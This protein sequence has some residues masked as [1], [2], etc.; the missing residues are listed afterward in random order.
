VGSE[1]EGIGPSKIDEENDAKHAKFSISAETNVERKGAS[2]GVVGYYVAAATQA[3]RERV[4]RDGPSADRPGGRF[5]CPDHRWWMR[6][7]T[8]VLSAT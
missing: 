3:F 2:V 8:G 1:Q 7:P 6:S 5:A 4:A